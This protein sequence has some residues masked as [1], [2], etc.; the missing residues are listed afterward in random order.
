[1]CSHNRPGVRRP[2]GPTAWVPL[3]LPM[4]RL[5]DLTSLSFCFLTRCW[6]RHVT[7]PGPRGARQVLAL[8]RASAG[9]HGSPS[10]IRLRQ[11]L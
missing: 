11:R 8:T 1:M 5:S 3:A 2:W 10:G 6:K 9:S 4:H 7:V